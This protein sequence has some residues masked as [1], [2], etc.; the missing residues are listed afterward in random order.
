VL[1]AQ[2]IAT[3]GTARDKRQTS[4]FIISNFPSDIFSVEYLAERVEYFLAQQLNRQG[5]L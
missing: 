3:A 5:E 4:D 1:A 2:V